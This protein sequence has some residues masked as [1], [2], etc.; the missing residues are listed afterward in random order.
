[1]PLPDEHHR[2]ALIP[3][4]IRPS[5]VPGYHE[6]LDAI[7]GVSR[8]PLT[9]TT[10]LEKKPRHRSRPL[11]SVIHKFVY[12]HKGRKVK[13]R[14]NYPPLSQDRVSKRQRRGDTN[15]YRGAVL[16]PDGRPAAEFLNF[17]LQNEREAER[18]RVVKFDA[19]LQD[20]STLVG[21]A[22]A[23]ASEHHAGQVDK[24][25]KPYIEH[26]VRVAR[27]CSS[28]YT[29]AAA[30]LHDIVSDTNVTL[31]D[32]LKVMP[33]LVCMMV[34][35]LTRQPT[36]TRWENIERI[37]THEGATE[38]KLHDLEDNLDLSRFDG[39]LD[40][41]PSSLLEHYR[42]ARHYLRMQYLHQYHKV[43]PRPTPQQ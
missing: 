25:G 37:A 34:H 5:D 4:C 14:P 16:S 28:P 13:G 7:R 1:M 31:R 9:L 41:M 21:K 18:K 8:R 39:E 27:R 40:K 12:R 42:K 38:I 43:I 24:A 3:T 10:L 6:T 19:Q 11:R 23:I 15:V 29:Q 26:L 30:L 35:Y 33:P 2:P 17:I 20:S 36:E 22:Y 32:L